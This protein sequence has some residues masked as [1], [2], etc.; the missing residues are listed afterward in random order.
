MSTK[1]ECPSCRTVYAG[2]EK[3]FCPKDGTR[4]L[5]PA[6]ARAPE[7]NFAGRVIAGRFVLDRVLGLEPAA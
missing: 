2:D 6:V 1:R 4:L 3:L 7:D 5:E